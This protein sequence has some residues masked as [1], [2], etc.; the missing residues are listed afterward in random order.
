MGAP[1]ASRAGGLSDHRPR[2][3][4]DFHGVERAG[5]VARDVER[6]EG[7]R[8]AERLP[9]APLEQPRRELG[10]HVVHVDAQRRARPGRAGQRLLR[11]Q[12][13]RGRQRGVLAAVDPKPAA[14]TPA[15]ARVAPSAPAAPRGGW[16]GAVAGAARARSAKWVRRRGVGRRCG[17]G[18]AARC[19][20]RRTSSLAGRSCASPPRRT[21]PPTLPGTARRGSRSDCARRAAPRRRAARGCSPAAAPASEGYPAAGRT[22]TRVAGLPSCATQSSRP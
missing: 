17:V 22:A 8:E 10:G 2:V 3:Q 15:E 11:L 9:A 19:G 16:W 21:R 7:A 18:A 6:R 14:V 1:L 4:G 5:G 12:A 20:G 13:G